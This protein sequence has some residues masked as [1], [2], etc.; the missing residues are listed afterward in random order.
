MMKI[1]FISQTLNIANGRG[2]F[3]FSM[4]ETMKK[5]FKV[6]PIVLVARGEKEILGAKAVLHSRGCLKKFILNP[7]LIAFYARKA[8]IIHG[9]DGWPWGIYTYLA[10]RLNRKPFTMTLYGTYAVVPL[11]RRWQK[12]L[13]KAAYNASSFSAAISHYTAKQI[14][15]AY[16]AARVRVINQGIKFVN[17]QQPIAHQRITPNPYI[18]TVA[19]LKFRKGYHIA[20]PAFA[21]LKKDF[22]QLKYVILASYDSGSYYQRIKKV[23]TDY[24][25]EKDIIWLTRVKEP[26]LIDLYKQADLFILSSVSSLSSHSFEGFGS[27]NLEAQACGCPVVASRGG[28][29]EDALVDKET[30]FLVKE[31]NVDSVYRAAKKIL[32]NKELRQQMSIRAKKFAQSMDWTNNLKDYYKKYQEIL[33]R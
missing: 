23:I 6:E 19:A 2:R 18:L 33:S 28:G 11:Y 1:C 21:K 16:P 3:A 30:G 7:M 9:F 13:M 4:I 26:E 17:Y 20:L 31:K 29:Q 27:I 10:S 5:K 32:S 25:L 15:K 24:N 14:K 22:P 8:D 12:I